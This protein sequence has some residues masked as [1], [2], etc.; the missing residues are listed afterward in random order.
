MLSES[1]IKQERTFVDDGLKTVIECIKKNAEILGDRE[2]IVF[3]SYKGGREVVTWNEL[4]EKSEAVAKSFVKLGI[5][6]GDFVAINL[7][8]CPQWL[9][10]AFGAMTAGACMASISFTYT[11]GSDLVAT[12]EKIKKCKVLV[13]DPGVDGQNWSIVKP[14][15]EEYSPD[16]EVRSSRMPYLKYLFGYE[17]D[18]EKHM[19]G[20][21]KID[22]VINDANP[23]VIL[24]EITENMLALLFQTS[25]ST[26]V[27][28]L[29]AHTHRNLLCIREST[30]GP[31]TE[32]LEA[33][34]VPFN[35]RPFTW[36]GG[37]PWSVISGQK[38]VTISGFEPLPEDRVAGVIDVITRE[39][40]N[41][42]TALPPMI[43]EMT[44]RKNELP[45]DW[46]LTILLTGGQPLKNVISEAIGS[47][48]PVL[49]SIY[50]GTEFSIITSGLATGSNFREYLCGKLIGGPRLEIK[51]VDENEEIVPVN[52]RGELYVRS[53]A[54]FQE[55]LNDPV[56]TAAVK[57]SDGWYKSDDIGMINENGELFIYGR[58]SFLII[59]G[60][61]NV[62]PEILEHALEQH[63]GV[64]TAVVVPIPDEVHYQVPCACIL[65]EKGSDVTE[66]QMRAYCEGIHNDKVGLFTI[67][68]K[69]YLFF[70][71]LPE[72]ITGKVSRPSLIKIAQGMVQDLEN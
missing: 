49:L 7:R 25:G 9:Y 58:K 6:P 51:I 52:T 68:P 59:S 44:I 70:E 21:G 41:I 32:A 71:T 26:G 5:R 1:Y 64:A 55:Y 27:P 56:K 3:A 67:L 63:P 47:V 23:D 57:T 34:N 36:L 15:L 29:V 62:A 16:G 10:A 66:E 2:A 13:M 19:V 46:P 8:A 14:F 60:G 65:R 12:M 17:K 50:G 72:T 42:L 43:H 53:D 35:D 45:S 39:R 61:M 48:A 4:K 22:D 31:A 24:P 30:S 54:I 28:K 33:K 69:Y 18:E 38:R 20:V 40:C 37:F 11:D